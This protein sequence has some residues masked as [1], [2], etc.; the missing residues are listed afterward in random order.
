M[1][2]IILA[3]GKGTRLSPLTQSIPKGM[4]KIFGKS[5]LDWQ[6]QTL[7][8][9]NVNDISIVTGYCANCINFK[10]VNYFH[11]ANFEKTNMV[12]TLFCAKNKLQDQTIISYGD[13][14]YE[15]R[16]LQKLFEST[17]DMAVVID[18]NWKSY[19]E[20]RFD[21][22][23]NDAESL[24]LD[25]DNFILNI[26]QKTNNI[27]KIQGQ[28]IGLMK[29]QNDGI[30]KIKNF[31]QESKSGTNPIN[32]DLSFEQSYMTDFL[33]GLINR[34]CKIKAIPIQNG[35]LELDSMDD[36]ILYEKLHSSQQLSNF[37]RIGA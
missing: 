29:F 12:E 14:I 6:I 16:V 5:M 18:K 13:I 1:N 31:Y 26:G 23:L 4:V 10:D 37:F 32:P 20:A 17:S 3:A 36:F 35:W 8:N 33:Q 2:S 11:N 34:G 22:P 19:W 9:C 25:D 7:R 15:C 24:I 28:Y 21:N 27:D 30:S